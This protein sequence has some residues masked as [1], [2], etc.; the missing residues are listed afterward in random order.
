MPSDWNAFLLSTG[1]LKAWTFIFAMLFGM[2]AFEAME[3]QRA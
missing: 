3:R 1:A 2:A